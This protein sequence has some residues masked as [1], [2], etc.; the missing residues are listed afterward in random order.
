MQWAGKGKDW[1]KDDME[2]LAHLLVME[3]VLA[4]EVKMGYKNSQI[5]YTKVCR[6]LFPSLG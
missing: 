3:D 1:K 4:E 5:V 2:R 6:Y